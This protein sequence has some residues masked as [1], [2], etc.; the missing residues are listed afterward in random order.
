V[1]TARSNFA[2]NFFE[3][4]GI[5]TVGNGGFDSPVAAASAFS[6]SGARLA[7]ICSSDAVY[8]ERADAT[9]LA[10]KEAGAARVYLAGRRETAG[11]DEQIFVG[12]DVVDALGRALDTLGVS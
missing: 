12:C 11:V 8:D 9:A 5:E 10:L 4:A 2:K 7:C 3:V 1:H 6:A